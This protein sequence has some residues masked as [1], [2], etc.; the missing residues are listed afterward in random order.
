[1]AQPE[2]SSSVETPPGSGVFVNQNNFEINPNHQLAGVIAPIIYVNNSGMTATT[3]PNTVGSEPASVHGDIVAGAFVGASLGVAPNV[4]LLYN[5]DADYFSSQLVG[6]EVA[7]PA[8]VVNMS[9]VFT[10][11]DPTKIANNQQVFDNYVDKFGTIFVA[12]AG[13]GGGVL[14]PASAYNVIAVGAF[15]GASSVGPVNGR[16]KPDITAPGDSTSFSTPYVSGIATLMVQAANQG[17]AGNS[18]AV[19]SDAVDPRTVKA[20]LLNGATKTNDW[21]NSPTA[22]LNP[23]YGS[24]IVNAVG[25]YKILSG[26]EFAPSATTFTA[27]L[28]GP[29]DAT[30]LGI[31]VPALGWDFKS[32]TSVFNDTVD[33]YLL[34]LSPSGKDYVFTATLTWNRGINESHPTTINNL[35]LFLYNATTNTPITASVSTVDNV[36]HIYFPM[37]PPGQYDLQVLKHGNTGSA[38]FITPLETYSLA[39]SAPLLGDVNWDGTVDIQDLSVLTNHW[40]TNQRSVFNGDVNGDG[41]VDIQDLSIVTNNWQSN[42][43]SLS[44]TPAFAAAAVPEPAGLACLAAGSGFLLWR[45]R[46]A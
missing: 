15:G 23:R 39:W 18:F 37:L 24:G 8:K 26:G 6:M 7:I 13:D 12:G 5:Y 1:V 35:D 11:T 28:N 21:T 10:T 20:I 38:D 43:A 22:P 36:E 32:I 16:S 27:G 41:F 46:R 3:F 17:A 19:K 34:N 25:S 40:Q 2:A 14:V 31:P 9:F 45:R 33:H 44:L 4:S 29:H 42:M 30:N